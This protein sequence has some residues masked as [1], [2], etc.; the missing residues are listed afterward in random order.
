MAKQKKSI[1]VKFDKIEL[2]AVAELEKAAKVGFYVEK[3][4][5]TYTD[6]T[7]AEAEP[8]VRLR[9]ES[10]DGESEDYVVTPFMSVQA[11]IT[12]V[13]GVLFLHPAIMN[14]IKQV[15]ANAEKPSEE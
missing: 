5:L 9:C 10:K 13:Q 8:L 2:P 4:E 7:T 3:R 12:M 1:Q 15:Q 6:P 11:L 14:V